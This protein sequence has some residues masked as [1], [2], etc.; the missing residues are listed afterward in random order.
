M[1]TGGILEKSEKKAFL[2]DTIPLTATIVTNKM[3]PKQN[4]V[5][6]KSCLLV[7]SV[8]TAVKWDFRQARVAKPADP[9]F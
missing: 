9:V 1:A 3:V 4:Y 8:R 2:D 5:V 6:S 7:T